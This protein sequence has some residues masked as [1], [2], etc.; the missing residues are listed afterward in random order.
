MA[1]DKNENI[2]FTDRKDGNVKIYGR[3]GKWLGCLNY[4]SRGKKEKMKARIFTKNITIIISILL[5]NVFL[6]SVYNFVRNLI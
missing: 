1:V 6:A 4:L 3:G 2:Y 5:F